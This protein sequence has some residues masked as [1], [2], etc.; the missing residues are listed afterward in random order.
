MPPAPPSPPRRGSAPRSPPDPLRDA[1]RFERNGDLAGAITSL[2]TYVDAHPDDDANRLRFAGLLAQA[3]DRAAARRHLGMLDRR[4]AWPTDGGQQANRA[5]AEIDEAEGAIASAALRWER[6]LADDID[7]PQARARL[8][9]LRPHAEAVPLAAGESAT[10]VSPEGVETLR[11]RLVRELGRGA[12]SAVYLARDEMLGIFIA[13]KV[14]HPQLAAPARSE[15]RRRFFAEARLAAA[16]RHPGVIAIYDLDEP[17]RTLSMEF[18]AGGTLRTRLRGEGPL[19]SEEI[20]TVATSLLSALA[21]VHRQGVV[22]GDLK[23]SNLLLRAPGQVVLA[24]FGIAQLT[25]S[26]GGPVVRSGAAEAPAG[27][28]LYLAPEQF[29]GAPASRATDLFAA[30]AILWEVLTGAPLRG[31]ADLMTGLYHP[32]TVKTPALAAL[33]PDTRRLATLVAQLTESD[34]N[35]RPESAAVALAHLRP[36]DARDTDRR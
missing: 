34:P 16:L 36:D 35:Q 2:R 14:L 15:A 8:R 26:D 3:G 30:G 23:P 12:T 22:H 1:D 32:A 4:G 24:D 6:V 20:I 13:L 31:Q 29:Q 19:D 10:L 11:Y 28:P 9:A 25:A 7:D 18:L 5:L 21:Y 27:T 17:T 33:S